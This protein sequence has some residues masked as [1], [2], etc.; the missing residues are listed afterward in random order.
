MSPSNK[1]KIRIVC[2]SD[3]HNHKPGQGFT[4]PAGDI[5]I[6]A[7]DLTNQGS[8]AELHKAFE[9]LSKTDFAAKVAVAGNHD[10]GL[11][12]NYELKYHTGWRVEV[13][14]PT[15]CRAV[16]QEH[17]GI[18][19]LEHSSTT[20]SLPGKDCQLKIF[21]SPQSA[22]RGNQNWAFQYDEEQAKTLWD[23]IASETDIL[24]THTPPAG[25]CDTSTHWKSGGCPALKQTLW[26]VRPL[27]HICGHCHEGRGAEVIRWSDENEGEGE[28]IWTWTDPGHGNKKQSLLDLTGSRGGWSLRAGSETAVVNASVMAG[29]FG[30]GGKRFNKPIAIDIEVPAG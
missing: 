17:Q 19:Y 15:K 12:P 11:D 4:L 27:I 23:A 7:G 21:G 2:I 29:S 10:L 26:R 9:W 16:L 24:I 14:D 28:V 20:V 30:R 25:H 6:H 13:E 8:H 1:Q 22:D 5:L 3:T 18:T